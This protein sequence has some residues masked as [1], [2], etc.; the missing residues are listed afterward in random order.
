MCRILSALRLVADAAETASGMLHRT[1]YKE[2]SPNLKEKDK[3]KDVS[4]MSNPCECCKRKLRFIR[5]ING[6]VMHSMVI[7]EWFVNYFGGKILG[8]VKLEAP[9]GNTYDVRV[10]ENM[11]RTILKSGWAAF[12][13]ANQIE[14]NYSLM[15]RYLG[16]AHFEVTIFD[17][18][19]K[20]KALSCARMETA[21]D[22]KTP[23]SR[24]VDNSS[25]SL[26][27]TTRS[28]S[29]E[30][31]DS[32]GCPNQ[33]S[34]RYCESAK[35]AASSYNSEEFSEDNPS[36]EDDLQMLPKD[37][38][39]SGRC[40]LTI[41]QKEK[42]HALAAEIQPKTEVLVVQMK[43][44]NVEP[45]ADLVIRKSYALVYFPRES[46]AVTLQAKARRFTVMVHLLPRAPGGR[47][48]TVTT[49]P[50]HGRT[51]A[52]IDL[53]ASVKEEEATDDE[54]ISSPGPED[55]GSSDNPEGSFEPPF[56]L[57]D[58][59]SLTQAQ[60]MKVREKVEAIKIKSVLPIYVA[61]I[62]GSNVGSNVRR[63]HS[64]MSFY[65]GT[66]YVSRYLEKKYVTGHHGKR[67]VISLVL[68]REG[69]NRT[70]STEVRRRSD[71]TMISK[72]WASFSRDNNLRKDDLCL[73]KLME[74]EEPLKMMV[75][76]IRREK[77]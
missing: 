9:N 35:M 14:E 39:L 64:G 1:I 18:N 40:V 63:R 61:V 69:K 48:G 49:V 74:N 62:N 59:V 11:N 31:S 24:H 19:G 57:S 29:A 22:V 10:T 6:N 15:F 76:I 2:V 8:T 70:W 51:S 60:E 56:M 23:N 33:G 36:E 38:V 43:K 58:R 46:Q 44:T 25:T 47:T 75:Y 3:I 32:D 54:E 28:S 66:R 71:C 7:P 65:F 41:A 34:C 45:Y 12:V 4:K 26:D 16:N 72:G 73:F 13:D 68:Q 55:Y 30:R 37:F 20:E 27:G 42:M 67:N 77:C 17:S 50:N 53:T 52:K 21:S 5:Q